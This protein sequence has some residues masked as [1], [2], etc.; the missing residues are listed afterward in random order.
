[1]L[2]ALTPIKKTLK[3]SSKQPP[4][5]AAAACLILPAHLLLS[6]IILAVAETHHG[7]EPHGQRCRLRAPFRVRELG[8]ALTGTW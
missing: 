5:I 6:I 8:E 7:R 1:M 4:L 2:H 3:R